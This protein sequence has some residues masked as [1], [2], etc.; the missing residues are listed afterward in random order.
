MAWW[1]SPRSSLENLTKLSK[2]SKVFSTSQWVWGLKRKQ[3][4]LNNSSKGCLFTTRTFSMKQDGYFLPATRNTAFYSRESELKEIQRR[5][6]NQSLKDWNA[7]FTLYG[8]GGVGKSQVALHYALDHMN[9][10]DAILWFHA[11]TE[12]SLDASFSETVLRLQLHEARWD[13]HQTS[14]T[15]LLLWF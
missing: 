7:S 1:L 15:K 9:D 14:R 10:F 13:D 3:S 4:F 6:T 5:L 12:M 2:E 8:L 11:Q